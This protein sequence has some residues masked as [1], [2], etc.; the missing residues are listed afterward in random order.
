MKEVFFVRGFKFLHFA[1]NVAGFAF[2]WNKYG[3]L[4]PERYVIF[5][6]AVYALILL[7]LVRT[8]NAY[9]IEY[10]TATDIAFSLSLSSVISIAVTYGITAV[11]WEN[12]YNPT[13]FAFLLG[14]QIVFN[15]VWAIFAVKLYYRIHKPMKTALIYRDGE[16]LKRLDDIKN[17]SKKYEVVCKVENPSS[18][19]EIIAATRTCDSIFVSGINATLRNG[20]VKYCAERGIQGFFLPH[21]GDIIMMGG[22]H[23]QAFSIPLI[24]TRNVNRYP[25]YLMLKRLVDIIVSLAGII[26]TSPIMILVA[27]AVKVQDGG[28][29]FYRQV[30]LTKNGRKFK[31]IKFRSMRPDAEKNGIPVLS[32]GENDD[33]ITRVGKFIRA[34]RLDELPQLFNVLKGDMSLVGPR[35]ERP[36]IAE[37]YEKEMPSFHLRLQAKAGLTGYAQIYGKYN[38]DPH[39]K[40]VMDLIYIN[41]VSILLDIKLMFATVRVLFLK[42]S[43]EGFE[44]SGTK[45]E[46]KEKTPDFS[47]KV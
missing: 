7:W 33:R 12:F 3:F 40:L 16:D 37:I 23:A 18:I 36:E 9:L 5:V 22:E 38:T 20:V 46:E 10:S 44:K 39:D 1:L 29:V 26:V 19:D 28:P 34:T 43:T 47:N 24:N 6:F 42:K 11:A 31:I 15:I 8:Y 2:V 35:P 27:I 14:G 41:K 30:R 17:F 25:E 21:I 13:Y 45:T 4:I 32:T